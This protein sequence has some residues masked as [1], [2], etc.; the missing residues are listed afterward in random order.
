[1]RLRRPRRK[2]LE[3][4]SDISTVVRIYEPVLAYIDKLSSLDLWFSIFRDV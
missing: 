2:I 1:M 4:G 3:R